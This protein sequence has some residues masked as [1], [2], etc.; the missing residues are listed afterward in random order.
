MFG[1]IAFKDPAMRIIAS[2]VGAVV[3]STAARANGVEPQPAPP[4]I[5]S[6]ESC[7]AVFKGFFTFFDRNLHGLAGNGRACADC[8]MPSDRFQLSPA[9]VERRF[10]ALQ[11][12]RQYYPWADDPLFRAVDADDFRVS[13]QQASDFSNLR[14]SALIRIEI[15]LPANVK[16]IDPATNTPSAE[17]VADVWRAVPTIND[18]RLTGPNGP[19]SWP[20]EPNRN[21]G[22]QLDARFAT[23]QEQG[24]G[25]LL[26]H[27]Q[28][29]Q[30]PSP[31]LLDNLAAF[32]RT[33]FTNFRVRALALA[34]ASSAT[35][36][37]EP[38]PPLNAQ[39]QHGKTVF[40][41]ACGHCH[42]GPGL[43]TPQLPVTLQ[44]H[45]IASQCP[46][47]VDA[48]VPARFTF[49]A[50]PE[51]LA[52]NA[53]TYEFTLPNGSTTRRTSSDP[54]RALLTGFVGGPPPL[55][56]WNKLDVPGLRG[57]RNTAP[58]FHN[59]SADTLEE[60]VDHYIGFFDRVRAVTPSGT[61][62]PPV[63]STDGVNYDRQLN[64]DERALLLAYLRKL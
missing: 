24:N 39:E 51:R 59:N 61:P 55:D 13:G 29:Q 37:P 38:D 6:G 56:D 43:S 62:A 19:A 33:T 47:P 2:L 5:C 9:S 53:R 3:L 27:A 31:T 28:I 42:G 52:R 40:A 26:A 1:N 16:L 4:A 57:I 10:Q 8:H 45:D 21:G 48:Q 36:L 30:A 54:G 14:H 18:V 34:V 11:K 35:T 25:A 32:Q 22:Y 44:Y 23:L 49:K 46:R 12:R 64:A 50:C 60:V 58:Y 63:A 17:T 41:R 7:E 15:P 20:R